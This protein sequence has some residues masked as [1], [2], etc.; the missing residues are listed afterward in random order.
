MKPIDQEPAL[1]ERV[2]DAIVDSILDGTF[3]TGDRL[4]QEQLADR[5]NVSRQPVSHALSLLK[6]QGVLVTLGRKGLTL[7]PMDP[8]LVGRLYQ[9]RGPL[10]ALAARLCAARVAAN[11]IGAR[12]FRA[13]N[14]LIERNAPNDP[15]RGV[16]LPGRQLTRQINADMDFH[17][18][19]YRL[20]GNS[21]IEDISRAH[22]VHFRRSMRAVL[23]NPVEHPQVWKDHREILNAVQDGDSDQ[24]HR[25]SV[26]HCEH[27]AIKVTA[28]MTTKSAI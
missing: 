23:T 21:L 9:V 28:S 27:A 22:W 13:L 4:A 8:A 18:S 19:L 1:T 17:V 25:L 5:L 26:Q 7:A 24:A 3:Q 16:D 14:A 2:R 6:E 15:K 11:E 12:D 10:D 20:S